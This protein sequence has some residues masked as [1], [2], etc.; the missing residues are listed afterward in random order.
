MPAER[1]YAGRLIDPPAQL[2][3]GLT[4]RPRKKVLFCVIFILTRIY[5]YAIV[6]ACKLGKGTP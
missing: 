5:K 2:C 6:S 1:G 3:A 4:E